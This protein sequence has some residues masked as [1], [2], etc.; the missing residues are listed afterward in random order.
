[1]HI[2]A[3]QT[4]K[5]LDGK[6]AFTGLRTT[7]FKVVNDKLYVGMLEYADTSNFN[8]FVQLLS[9][10]SSGFNEADLNR[11]GDTIIIHA[12]FPNIDHELKLFY[13]SND[14]NVIRFAGDV[15]FDSTRV[16]VTNS[17]CNIIIPVCI[18]R[19]YDQID[20]KR[21]MALKSNDKFT[22]DDAFEFLLRLNEKLKSR[23]NRC[24]AGFTDAYMNEVLIEM[25]FNPIVK[26]TAA[27]AVW[28][29]T[30][31][32]TFYLKTKFSDDQTLI[33]LSDYI[34]NWYLK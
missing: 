15:F 1:M 20:L 16:I 10:D 21:I 30:S 12:T 22:R 34:F 5:Q 8:R 14:S 33:K 24:Y 27:N 26:R 18:N 13:L 11:V 25:G 29:N 19:L 7:I 23:C 17:N 9:I 3:A 6:W 31:G 32:F 2:G 28:Y 4:I